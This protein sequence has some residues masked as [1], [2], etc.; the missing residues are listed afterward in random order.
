MTDEKKIISNDKLMKD[1]KKVGYNTRLLK[2][3]KEVN[4]FNMS[5]FNRLLD[6]FVTENKSLFDTNIY[7]ILTG[8]LTKF[9]NDYNKFSKIIPMREIESF[10]TVFTDTCVENTEL[11]DF[12]DKIF[13]NFGV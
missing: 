1:I 12:I 4:Y 2:I 8:C 3:Y 11:T 10:C 13:K 7:G 9:I 5:R 6:Q